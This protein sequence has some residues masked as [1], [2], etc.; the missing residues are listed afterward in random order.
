MINFRIGRTGRVG[1][2]GRATSFYDDKCVNDQM[3]A[4]GLVKILSQA[5]QVVPGWLKREADRAPGGNGISS[6]F[7]AFG[8][9]NNNNNN[10]NNVNSDIRQNIFSKSSMMNET[11]LS[12]ENLDDWD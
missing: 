5:Q 11:N 7:G 1:N 2:T 6:A 12:D 3:L 4:R 9:F 10:N 8:N